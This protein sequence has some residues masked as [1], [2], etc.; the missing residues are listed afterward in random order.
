M[1]ESV[2]RVVVF[3]DYQNVHG[4]VRRQFL[5]FGTDPSEGHVFP[6]KIGELLTKRRQPESE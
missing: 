3:M 2:D 6:L 5:P 1:S 4:W